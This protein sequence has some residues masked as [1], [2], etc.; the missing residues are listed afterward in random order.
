MA[1]FYIEAT[2]S[3]SGEVEANTREEAESLFLDDLNMYYEGTDSISIE[4]IDED[5]EETE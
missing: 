1:K 3:Y 2:Y 4:E 5:D